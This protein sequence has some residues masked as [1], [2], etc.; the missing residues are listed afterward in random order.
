MQFL[1]P[2]IENHAINH[3]ETNMVADQFAALGHNMDHNCVWY[4]GLIIFLLELLCK[5]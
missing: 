3:L 4:F 1:F 5:F 2:F